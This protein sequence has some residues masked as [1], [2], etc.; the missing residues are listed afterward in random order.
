M[1][2]RLKISSIDIECINAKLK[3]IMHLI[4]NQR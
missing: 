3:E 2:L 1:P 4:D